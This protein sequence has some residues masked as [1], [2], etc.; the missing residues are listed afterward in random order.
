MR[1]VR[2]NSVTLVVIVL[3]IAFAAS[4]MAI[5]PINLPLIG[6]RE[7]V[8]LGLDLRGGVYLEYQ[9]DFTDVPEGQREGRLEETRRIIEKRV[10]EWGVTEPNIYTMSPDRIVVQVPGFADIE[11]AKELVGKTAELVFREPATSGNTSL[12]AAVNVGDTQITVDSV[13]DFGA[14]DVFAVGSG[15]TAE[16]KTI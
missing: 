14:Q 5:D 6:E 13:T 3:I 10:N 16:A 15:E 9:A 2:R 1:K 4:V 7:G 12:A 8:V 11:G